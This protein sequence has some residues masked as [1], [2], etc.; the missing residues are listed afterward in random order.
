MIRYAL[1]CDQGHVFESW[2]QNAAAFDGLQAAGHVTCPGCGSS[3]VEKSLMAPKVRPARKAATAPE[4]QA[5]EA[6]A[7]TP[8]AA[9][10]PE[11]ERAI[12]EMRARVEAESDYVGDSFARE[13]RAMH[14]GDVPERSIYGEAKPD[15]AR[16]LIE[17]GVP[18]LPLPFLPTRKT[19]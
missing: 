10:N 17:D 6:P 9:P 3:A 4:P 1:K 15:E 8:V 14:L 16:A 11:L 12:A 19:N 2:F 13:A 5:P 18:V 7:D